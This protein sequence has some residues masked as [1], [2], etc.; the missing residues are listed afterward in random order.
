MS[1][2]LG[3]HVCGIV[4]SVDVEDF[5]K[6]ALN[7]LADVVVANVNVLGTTLRDRVVCHKDRTLVVTADGKRTELVADLAHER[8]DPDYLA[9]TVAE[10]HVLSLRLSVGKYLH[11]WVNT[12]RYLASKIS[13]PHPCRY[14]THTTC[15]HTPTP[16]TRR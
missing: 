15:T 2:V 1:E 14:H 6:L 10:R 9:A 11:L 7:D 8:P 3:E 12:H 16:I 5:D 13:Y 4:V